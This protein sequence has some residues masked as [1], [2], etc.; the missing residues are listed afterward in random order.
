MKRVLLLHYDTSVKQPIILGI[1]KNQVCVRCQFQNC[2]VDD[3]IRG[4]KAY[5][6]INERQLLVVLEL[7]ETQ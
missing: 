1:G 2:R 4:G 6:L 5:H 3:G 7:F